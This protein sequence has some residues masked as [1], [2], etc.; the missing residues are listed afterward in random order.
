MTKRIAAFK[1]RTALGLVA[2][3]TALAALGTV[4]ASHAASSSSERRIM[5]PEEIDPTMV[6][7]EPLVEA[8]DRIQQLAGEIGSAFGGTALDTEEGAVIVYWKGQPPV[9]ITDLI[10]E[11][12]AQGTE[13]NVEAVAYSLAELDREALRIASLDSA[14]LPVKVTGVGPLDNYSGLLVSIDVGGNISRARQA[15]TS[16]Y[17][18]KFR[19]MPE[20]RMVARR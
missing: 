10:D 2:S 4:P 17:P 18:L 15:I 1:G 19:L 11:L 16:E 12:R 3:L 8:A 13:V 9:E 14:S 5:S 20:P 6:A 7:Q